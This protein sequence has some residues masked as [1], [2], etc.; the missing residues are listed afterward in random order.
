[1]TDKET[2]LITLKAQVYDLM[3]QRGLLVLQVDAIQG[4]VNEIADQI[5]ILENEI[6]TDTHNM[7]DDV[8]DIV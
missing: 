7:S 8:L 6:S 3:Q 2:R 1:M 5:K 4:Q